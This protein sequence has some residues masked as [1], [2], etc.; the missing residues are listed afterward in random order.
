MEE[1]ASAREALQTAGYHLAQTKDIGQSADN[2][3]ALSSQGKFIFPQVTQVELWSTH[4]GFR[5][6]VSF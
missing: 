5:N 3:L 1:S 2:F 6:D 4:Y